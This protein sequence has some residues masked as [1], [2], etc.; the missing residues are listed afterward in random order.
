MADAGR[1]LEVTSPA[2]LE[3]TVEGERRELHPIV[4]EESFRIGRE[5]LANAFAHSQARNIEVEV[6][7]GSAALEVRIRDDGSGIESDILNKGGRAGRWGI[8][9]MCERAAKI[10]GQLDIWSKTARQGRLWR[11]QAIAENVVVAPC[12]VSACA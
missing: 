8:L 11:L 10:R 2:R 4:H 3:L 5:A 6:S 12:P 7:Y 1:Q 9:G